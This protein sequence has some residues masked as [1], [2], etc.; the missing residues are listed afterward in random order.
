C[1]AIG[2]GA[3]PCLERSLANG[4]VVGL[5]H[6]EAF[7]VQHVVGRGASE[8][9]RANRFVE[10]LLRADPLRS[11]DGSKS[12]TLRDLEDLRVRVV[13]IGADKERTD[14]EVSDP[15]PCTISREVDAPEIVRA[16]Q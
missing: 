3:G 12:L 2:I 5:P 13:V 8:S 1:R 16:G 6:V 11:V 7:L 10:L 15:S 14:L 4:M 9:F